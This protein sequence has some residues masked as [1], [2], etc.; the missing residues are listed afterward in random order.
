MKHPVSAGPQRI[1]E[2]YLDQTFRYAPSYKRNQDDQRS[3]TL[4]PGVLSLQLPPGSP[5]NPMLEHSK[6]W[7]GEHLLA[8]QDALEVMRV[9]E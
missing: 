3:A 7:S 5:S 9:T 4:P 6:H 8:S 2:I 1:L